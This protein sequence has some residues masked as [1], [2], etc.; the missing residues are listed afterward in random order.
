MS[1]FLRIRQFVFIIRIYVFTIRI[2]VSVIRQ[3]VFPISQ[4]SQ[5]NTRKTANYLYLIGYLF[6]F[7]RI[8]SIAHMI[9]LS[10]SCSAFPQIIPSKTYL[11]TV[12]RSNM[13]RLYTVKICTI[14]RQYIALAAFTI[15]N[16]QRLYHDI[17]QYIVVRY[18]VLFV[19][20]R[21]SYYIQYIQLWYSQYVVLISRLYLCVLLFGN[22]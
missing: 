4:I 21:L 18:S 10:S 1:T 16:I 11:Y 19:F 14:Y 22:L 6:T 7:S 13:P 8:V 17:I 3:F 2:I 20:P 12:K 15:Y 5:N 9:L